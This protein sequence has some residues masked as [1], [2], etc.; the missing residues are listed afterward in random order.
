MSQPFAA[1]PVAKASLRTVNGHRPDGYPDSATGDIDPSGEAA[2]V[3]RIRQDVAKQLTRATRAHE[4]ATGTPMPTQE[5]DA[6]TRRLVTEALDV[7]GTDEMDGGRA[8]LHPQVESRISRTVTNTLLGAGGLQPWLNSPDVEGIVA[9]G[10]DQVFVTFTGNQEQRVAPIADSDEEMVELVRVLAARTG[11]EERRWDRAAPML[12]LQ[13]PDGSRLNAVMDVTR[14]PSLSI[15]RHRFMTMT[16]PELLQLGA[17]DAALAEFLRAAVAARLN[18]VAGGPTNAGKT[19][20]LRGLASAIPPYERLVT[21]EDTYEL[22][23]DADKQRHPNVVAMQ[24]RDAN[25]EGEGAVT[26]AMLFRNG[27]RMSPS[28]VFVGEVRGDEVI[29]LLNAMSQGNDGSMSTIH[30]SSSVGVFRK[31][32]LYAAQ[33]PE[34]LEQAT[35]NLHIAEGL[36]L[37]IQLRLT[38]DGR[39]FVTSVREVVDADGLQVASNEVFR[40][41]P[42]G[43]AVPGA[44]PSTGLME[45][46]VYHGFD[47]GLLQRRQ[48]WWDTTTTWGQQ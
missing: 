7:Y 16:L 13:L 1:F 21:I 3:R 30:A 12:N 43:R 46:L 10:C 45:K 24:A 2:L 15:R 38:L 42:D 33:S 4:T 20:F 22:G 6:L 27:L 25:V 32:A 41:G 39:R 26:M 23:F 44:P 31:L 9:N 48:G 35:T 19:T 17:I 5:R 36:H 18:M 28:R 34:R 29:P 8:R 47:P 37:V 14:R 40:P 11:N